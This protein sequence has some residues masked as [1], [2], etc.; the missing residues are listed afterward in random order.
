MNI[1][2]GLIF[3]LA[4]IFLSLPQ[5]IL[6]ADS[7]S[8][9]D[10][11]IS[12]VE[13]SIALLEEQILFEQARARNQNNQAERRSQEAGDL[14]ERIA[15]EQA[16][17]P[18]LEELESYAGTQAKQVRNASRQLEAYIQELRKLQKQN[19]IK[20]LLT[21]G[22][23]TLQVIH[24]YS[25]LSGNLVK[26]AGNWLAGK[27]TDQAM[28]ELVGGKE[29]YEKQVSGLLKDVQNTSPELEKLGEMTRLSME[30][31]Q[32]YLHKHEGKDIQGSTA[33]ILAKT[34]II[35]EQAEKAR[36]SLV[37]LEGSLENTAKGAEAQIWAQRDRVEQMQ[38]LL[39]ELNS[40]EDVPESLFEQRIQSLEQEIAELHDLL[41]RLEQEKIDME[42]GEDKKVQTGAD[43]DQ[44]VALY[45]SLREE[46]LKELPGFKE[47]AALIRDL[48]DSNPAPSL[49]QLN[50]QYSSELE[51][52]TKD[53]RDKPM[54]PDPTYFDISNSQ[55]I[56]VTDLEGLQ[57]FKDRFRL[58]VTAMSEH[59]Q[60]LQQ[61]LQG[62]RE[63]SQEI[64]NAY[65]SP[66]HDPGTEAEKRNRINRAYTSVL[67]TIDE[68]IS[69]SQEYIIQLRKKADQTTGSSKTSYLR[70]ITREES[71][72][73]ELEN[74]M[75][76]LKRLHQTFPPDPFADIREEVLSFMKY[77]HEQGLQQMQQHLLDFRNEIENYQKS[78]EDRIKV[79]EQEI[80]E[81]RRQ[82]K[83]QAE[84]YIRSVPQVINGI[85]QY[86]DAI[87]K[88]RSLYRQQAG[89]GI[90]EERSEF[91]F[92]LN[93]N[94]IA[95][96]AGDYAK[97]CQAIEFILE[98]VRP[99]ADNAEEL[100]AQARRFRVQAFTLPGAPL[101]A[102][103]EV[104]MPHLHSEV[105]HL[106]EKLAAKREVL[107]SS[108]YNI[109]HNPLS[110]LVQ[111]F[112]TN[113]T[114]MD[115]SPE[116]Y[117]GIQNSYKDLRA[118]IQHNIDFAKRV[119]R[120]EAMHEEDLVQTRELVQI[121]SN[122]YYIELSCLGDD[123][124]L[125]AEILRLL[126]ELETA[127]NRLDGKK[128][129][130]DAQG[131]ISSLQV[132]LDDVQTLP[133][134]HTS[135]YYDMVRD[136][137]SRFENAG[138]EFENNRKDFADFDVQ[139][140][141]EFLLEISEQ[142]RYHRQELASESEPGISQEEIKG[143]YQEFIN[144][145]ARGD[146]H[147]LLKLLAPGW[148]GGDGSDIRDV[149]EYLT[150]SF[151]VF[152][153]IQY[154]I[155]GFSVRPSSDGR[156]QV[157]YNVKIIGQNSKQRMKHEEEARIVEEVAKVDG[158]LCIMRTLSGS[159]WLK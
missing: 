5:S 50:E 121:F 60:R 7:T 94:W 145:Y 139:T 153:R 138:Q 92:I 87:H 107:N 27:I 102:W 152:E 68:T 149:E 135:E 133:M 140:A 112:F 62:I 77:Q 23:E 58:W 146:V 127:V 120:R 123:F 48:K 79:F 30:G 36:L 10:M 156:L 103:S 78:V 32:S 141:R 43:A 148:Q 111:G 45:E 17:L 6:R 39:Q 108:G 73:E 1:R 52:I 63:Q 115:N 95:E 117:Q 130:A 106:Q 114:L 154:R 19:L 75:S 134:G 116:I 51:R 11:K 25:T 12:S 128:V 104:N 41:S 66:S 38:S 98:K 49:E 82:Y 47:R 91:H 8:T 22:L 113:A 88:L 57:N 56:R 2:Y 86:V 4:V 109:P 44:A 97:N 93:K 89:Q 3:F 28:K 131:L 110:D 61:R 64:L 129:Y 16:V 90:L 69:N 118:R 99:L 29:Y 71:K 81:R 124:S 74:T 13:S 33:T 155:S 159:Q 76:N 35:L 65:S 20:T 101:S 53:N 18:G 151:R 157:M 105:A 158:K 31:W 96:S 119:E 21:M 59:A 144:F 70:L 147:G 80:A 150:N 143:M 54:Y 55:N 125:N 83:I 85:D 34:R 132:L 42:A 126:D 84:S 40:Q 14:L 136:T 15:Q 100:L 67:G 24:E 142:L 137:I 122:R 46:Y 26:D 9:I 37:Q 72:I